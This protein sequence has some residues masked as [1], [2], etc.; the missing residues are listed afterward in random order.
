MT[1]MPALSA[2]EIITAL[3]KIDFTET[4]QKG[5]H[6]LLKHSDGRTTVVPVHQG[7]TIGPGLL[8]KI[9]RDVEISR[10]DFLKLI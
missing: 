9:L 6:V 4:R 8:S 2:K 10:D 7:E 1:K 5:S 3:K